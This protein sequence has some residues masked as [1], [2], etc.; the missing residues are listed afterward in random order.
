MRAYHIAMG[1]IT[2]KA[3]MAFHGQ[4][5]EPAEKPP[6]IILQNGNG[7]FRAEELES[8]VYGT[9][10]ASTLGSVLAVKRCETLEECHTAMGALFADRKARKFHQV[11]P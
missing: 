8:T 7:E 4:P 6:Y 2:G 9:R 11:W 3:P 5:A 1:W 10:Y